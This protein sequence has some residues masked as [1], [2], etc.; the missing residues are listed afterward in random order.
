MHVRDLNSEED[1]SS[2][3]D[4][5]ESIPGEMPLDKEA[6]WDA[7]H[8]RM[9][10]K[11]RSRK[12]FWYYAAAAAVVAVSLLMLFGNKPEKSVAR[13]EIHNNPAP[14]KANGEAALVL[15]T[16]S[17]K[18]LPTVKS[19]RSASGK[20][21]TVKPLQPTGLTIND[22]TMQNIVVS[23]DTSNSTSD[24]TMLAITTP[25]MKKKLKVVHVN[26]I[27]PATAKDPDMA[28]KRQNKILLFFNNSGTS[29]PVAN[30]DNNSGAF[31]IKFNSAN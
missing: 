11:K 26:E 23:I 28:A 16:N 15:N 5:L 7:L 27:A 31:K 25:P 20:L 22:S 2:K 9:Q 10:N 14:S 18:T 24:T 19:S 21:P 12:F 6:L 4:E 13:K 3:L 8:D 17:Q 30:S 1:W 29:T